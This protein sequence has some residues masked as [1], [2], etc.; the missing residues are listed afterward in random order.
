MRLRGRWE[1]ACETLIDDAKTLL[2]KLW[3]NTNGLQVEPVAPIS[4][5]MRPMTTLLTSLSLILYLCLFLMHAG[6]PLPCL[7]KYH[8]QNDRQLRRSSH[9]PQDFGNDYMGQ[10]HFHHFH[11]LECFN[12]TKDIQREDAESIHNDIQNICLTIDLIPPRSK[13]EKRKGSSLENQ[14]N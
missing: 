5:S 11:S 13:V 14:D 4:I 2:G 3:L 9:L 7:G 1:P 8:K 6:C 12:K 10:D